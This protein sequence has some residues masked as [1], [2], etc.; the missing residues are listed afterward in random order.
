MADYATRM[1][2][3]CEAAG[4]SLTIKACFARAEFVHH[5]VPDGDYILGFDEGMIR[6]SEEFREICE[7][8]FPLE[9]L[10]PRRSATRWGFLNAESFNS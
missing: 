6:D 9:S 7:I 3:A 1:F 4:A 10:T 2:K 8:D 5:K